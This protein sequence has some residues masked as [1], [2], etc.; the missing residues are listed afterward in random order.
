[1]FDLNIVAVLDG[2]IFLVRLSC[3]CK[4][5]TIQDEWGLCHFHTKMLQE[6]LWQGLRDS[7]EK[8]GHWFNRWITGW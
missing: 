4:W 5:W 3:G 7:K 2:P 6:F 8:P 1:M